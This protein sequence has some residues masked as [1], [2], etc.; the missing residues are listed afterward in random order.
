MSLTLALLLAIFFPSMILPQIRRTGS[1]GIF[2]ALLR[3]ADNSLKPEHAKRE[4]KKIARIQVVSKP[5][6]LHVQEENTFFHHFFIVGKHGRM[7]LYFPSS[8]VSSE[9]ILSYV[10]QEGLRRWECERSV[11]KMDLNGYS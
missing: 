6:S 10:F 2:S 11:Q 7:N 9:R 4:G 1:H 5:E 8:S 3:A